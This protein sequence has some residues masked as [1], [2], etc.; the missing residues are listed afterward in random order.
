MKIITEDPK[1]RTKA[2]NT[3]KST[4]PLVDN[5]DVY[6]KILK[7]SQ[8]EKINKEEED[9]VIKILN[10]YKKLFNKI[11]L[12]SDDFVF[13]GH[14]L[15]E[16]KNKSQ[17]DIIR[18][19]VYRYKFNIFPIIKKIQDYPPVMQL[20]LSSVCNLRCVMCYQHD[21]SFSS[22]SK[23]FMG[24]MNL[25]LF[26]KIIDEIEGKMEAITFASRGE[27]TLN[28]D[29]DKHLKYCE[30]KFMGLKL[31][32]N[33]TMFNEKIINTLLSSDLETL[34]ISA[35]APNKE[36]YEKIRVNAKFDKVIK[37][38]ELFRNIR[39]KNYKNSKLKVRV[40]GV[41]I[42]NDQSFEEI[43][44]FY[45]RFADEVSL[46]NYLPWESSYENEINDIIEPCTDLWRIMFVFWDGKVNPC[47][48][49]YKSTLSKWNA[50][51]QTIKDIWN[52]NYYNELR[53]KHLSKSRKSLEPCARCIAT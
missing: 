15:N 17:T 47:D 22:N 32:T 10:Y 48:F 5:K 2:F 4:A 34:V 25:E 42:N 41:K 24:Y 8:T 35:D 9:I 52:S 33:A 12:D 37:N 26:K 40:S 3:F 50:K 18:Y 20:E 36:L 53:D 43:N 45:S 29:L 30:K 21:K 44:K 49:D 51:S 39:E 19:I 6:N 16:V 27:P 31:N 11:E 46:M 1:I 28:K 38:L 14:E 23:G 7:A 13:S